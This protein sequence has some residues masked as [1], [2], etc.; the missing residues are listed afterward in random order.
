M[1]ADMLSLPEAEVMPLW[2]TTLHPMPRRAQRQ[3]ITPRPALHLTRRQPAQLH[4]TQRRRMPAAPRMA[5]DRIHA[6]P[7]ERTT[8]PRS[9]FCLGGD[10]F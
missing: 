5:A 7:C 3:R 6:K 2:R 1:V 8:C 10:F 4:P 9:S